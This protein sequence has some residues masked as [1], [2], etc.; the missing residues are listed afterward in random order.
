MLQEFLENFLLLNPIKQKSMYKIIAPIARLKAFKEQD[1]FVSCKDVKLKDR[2]AYEYSSL[3]DK[4]FSAKSGYIF[5]IYFYTKADGKIYLVDF[6][7][8]K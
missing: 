1:G 3:R 6:T 8:I 2:S 4:N 7:E 5:R